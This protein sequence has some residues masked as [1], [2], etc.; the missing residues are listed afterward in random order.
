MFSVARWTRGAGWYLRWPECGRKALRG[1]RDTSI[2]PQP[3]TSLCSGASCVPQETRLCPQ[4]RREL[5]GGF[6]TEVSPWALF[7]L[8]S[9]QAGPKYLRQ[10]R[11]HSA[12]R[13]S[14][15]STYTSCSPVTSCDPFLDVRLDTGPSWSTYHSPWV[16]LAFLMFPCGSHPMPRLGSPPQV[17]P[18][19]ALGHLLQLQIR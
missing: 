13:G 4:E 5:G 2:Q 17:I 7:Y 8:D 11:T 18:C 19:L 3:R 16:S 10:P 9:D 15:W 14:S 6:S 1:P 12:S